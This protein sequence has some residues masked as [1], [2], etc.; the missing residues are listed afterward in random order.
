MYDIDLTVT[1]QLTNE[2]LQAR[3]DAIQGAFKQAEDYYFVVAIQIKAIKDE[4]LWADDFESFEQC[5]ACYGVGRSHA[6]RLISALEFRDAHYDLLKG[7]SITKLQEMQRAGA[8]AVTLVENGQITPNMSCAKIRS[9]INGIKAL[10][11]ETDEPVEDMEEPETDE[12]VEDT[13]EQLEEKVVETKGEPVNMTIVFDD[14]HFIYI[15]DKAVL[16]Q[17]LEMLGKGAK[18]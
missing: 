1:K 14:D 15:E 5:V 9:I 7:F 13:D 4:Q 11:Q 16:K 18:K 3:V 6:Y 8:D 10:A 17:V 2:R 12:P